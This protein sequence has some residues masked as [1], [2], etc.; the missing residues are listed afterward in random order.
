MQVVFGVF[1]LTG[2]IPFDG[3]ELRFAI[4]KREFFNIEKRRI[5]A[6]RPNRPLQAVVTG[7]ARIGDSGK[8][9]CDAGTFVHYSGR[10]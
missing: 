5:G 10:R 7:K 6:I 4:G 1:P 2:F 8:K 9:R 3:K